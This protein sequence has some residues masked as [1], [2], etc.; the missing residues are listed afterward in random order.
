M[1][2][3]II[4]NFTHL[5]NRYILIKALDL[6][7][8]EP[9]FVILQKNSDTIGDAMDTPEQE[10]MPMYSMD[11]HTDS[12]VISAK[13]LDMKAHDQL[14]ITFKYNEKNPKKT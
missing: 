3:I 14:L 5:S 13:A 4:E 10:W 6:L 7:D 1:R 2:K 12:D 11:I 9:K 8:N